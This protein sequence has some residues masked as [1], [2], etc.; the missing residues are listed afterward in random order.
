MTAEV[1]FLCTGKEKDLAS[2][3]AKPFFEEKNKKSTRE[4]IYFYHKK[5]KEKNA[6]FKDE[7]NLLKH[8]WHAVKLEY[9]Q[10]LKNFSG[11]KH[12]QKDV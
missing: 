12:S 8:A 9:F 3:F 7:T 11:Q 2:V 10:P 6:I 4:F 1:R 5:R